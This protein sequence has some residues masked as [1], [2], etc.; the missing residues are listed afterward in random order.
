MLQNSDE[1]TSKSSHRESI[2]RS[3]YNNLAKQ[4]AQMQKYAAKSQNSLLDIEVGTVCLI[5]MNE[6]DRV[7]VDT[8]TLTTVLVEKTERGFYRLA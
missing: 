6:N 1:N 3:A 4:E 8:T 2:R 5:S 7:K